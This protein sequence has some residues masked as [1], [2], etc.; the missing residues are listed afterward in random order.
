M[1]TRG[2]VHDVLH[3]NLLTWSTGSLCALTEWRSLI[4]VN[5]VVNKDDRRN[6]VPCMNAKEQKVRSISLTFKA[7]HSV[8]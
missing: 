7:I 3:T 1:I 5:S 6:G 4:S 8:S 2:V